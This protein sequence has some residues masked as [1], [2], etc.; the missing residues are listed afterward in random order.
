MMTKRNISL[1][2]I[3]IFLCSLAM[4]QN[5]QTNLI[6]I[7]GR[8]YIL[9][10]GWSK[11]GYFAYASDIYYS[12]GRGAYTIVGVTIFNTVT[13]EIVE[14]YIKDSM[15][16]DD[17]ED[18][19]SLDDFLF[20]ESERIESLLER[21]KII[22]SSDL[23]MESEDALKSLY[24]LEIEFQEKLYSQESTDVE[25][26]NFIIKDGRGRRKN[27]GRVGG[28]YSSLE[29]LGYFK[30][31]FENRIVFLVK[32]YELGGPGQGDRYYRWIGCHLT[33]GF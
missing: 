19:P 15:D 30:N 21:N 28:L 10:I 33:I 1:V 17:D 5:S 31:P 3:F 4:A 12:N 29:I 16:Y 9:P 23:I 26:Y 32:I 6:N 8:N 18:F 13:D 20:S 2:F 27:I 24:G 22:L 14:Q 7:E 11:T 25:Y